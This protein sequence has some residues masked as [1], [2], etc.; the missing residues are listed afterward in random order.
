[1]RGAKN[2]QLEKDSLFNKWCWEN[3]TAAGKRMKLDDRL[4]AHTHKLTQNGERLE[5]KTRDPKTSRR[6]HR[7]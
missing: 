7:Q 5:L 1:M 6:K 3:R 4:L 2:I